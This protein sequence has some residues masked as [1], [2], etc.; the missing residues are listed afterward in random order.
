MVWNYI[1]TYIVF[2]CEVSE[3][4]RVECYKVLRWKE[5]VMC[6]LTREFGIKVVRRRGF[7]FCGEGGG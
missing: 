3:W 2:V 6:V 5:V 1:L 4:R 7:C